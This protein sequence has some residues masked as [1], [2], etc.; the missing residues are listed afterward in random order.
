MSKT[1]AIELACDYVEA[2]QFA[3]WL[4]K[5]GHTVKIGNSTGTYVEGA[6]GSADNDADEVMGRLWSEYCES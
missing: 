6:W 3:D 5:Q 1:Y 2:E 4:R